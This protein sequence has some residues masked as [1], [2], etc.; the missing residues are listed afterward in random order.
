MVIL[1]CA[2]SSKKELTDEQ[3]EKL[4]RQHCVLCHGI[5][6]TLQVNGAKDLTKSPYSLQDRIQQITK[7]KN[8]MT[9]YENIL[10]KEEIKALAEYTFK[11]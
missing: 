8:T 6:G 5:D 7:G 4:Y 11:L 1:A 2:E 9:P 10:T 3:V